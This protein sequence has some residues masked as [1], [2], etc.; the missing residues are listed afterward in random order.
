MR[1]GIVR[2]SKMF[3]ADALN[4]PSDWHIEWVIASADDEDIEFEILGSDFPEVVPIK[5]CRLIFHKQNTKIEV[6]EI[7]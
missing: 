3:I 5:E 4:F 2:I 1:K 6:E 7:D